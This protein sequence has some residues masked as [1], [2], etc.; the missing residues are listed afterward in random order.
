MKS[1]NGKRIW[2]MILVICLMLSLM[3]VFVSQVEVEAEAVSGIN[4]LTCSSFIS[5]STR[6]NYIDVMMRYY[7]NSSSTLQSQLNNGNSVVFMFEGGSD[8]YDDYAYA[9]GSGQTRLQAVCIVVQMDSSGNAYIAFYSEKCCSLPDDANYVT[10]GYETSGST[11][12][13][14]GIYKMTT[15]DHNG[16]YAAHTTTCSTGW[17]TPYD[18]T[19]GYSAACNGI[20]IHTRGVNYSLSYGGNSMGC[21]LIGYGANSS[22]EYNT[23]MKTVVGITFNAYDGTQRCYSYGSHPGYYTNT[24]YYVIDRQLGI[25]SPD[26]TE[27]GSG[28]MMELYTKG[29]ITGITAY[30]TS[31]RANADFDY[32]SECTYYPAHC[33]I[34]VTQDDT[35]VNSQPCSVGTV[36]ECATLETVSTG[37]TYTATGLYQNSYGNY[38][39][40]VTTSSGETGY[41]YG[42]EAEYV[43]QI[44]SDIG[45]T[46][47]DT[48]NGHVSGNIFYVTGK[49]ASKYNRIDTAAVWVHDGFGTSGTKVTGY[50][51][52]V[53][54][55][56]YTLDDSTID[57][58]T[59]FNSVPTGNHT[60]AISCTYTNYYAD[61]ATTLKSNTGTIS[62]VE[63]Y[64]V[65]VSSSVDQ[66]SCSH[67][68]TTTVVEEGT[69]TAPG[70][71]V[72]AC[73]TCGLV[74]ETS[75]GADGHSYGSWTTVG[76]TCT[77][78][79][80][81]KRTCSACGDVETVTI[82]ATGHS[83][84]MTK[85]EATCSAYAKYTMTCGSCG[86]SYSMTADQMASSWIEEIPAGM[87][88]S[89][90]NSQT[91][92]RYS[93]YQT[94][95]SSSATAPTGYT[96]KS[97]AWVQSG[98]G[99]IKYVSEW[100]SG[101]S[102]S[103][104]LY[105]QYN[106][107]SSKVTASESSTA[108]TVVNS[109]AVVGYLY[110]HWCYTD[111]YYSVASSSGSYTTFHAYYDTTDP[112]SYT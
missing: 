102:T 20:N 93:D 89:L 66:S 111:S 81:Q 4:S 19:T 103:S 25:L 22:N 107:K 91:Q 74:N 26:G 29:D 5:N 39:Y 10:P 55:F 59:A 92:Y 49:I 53:G 70:V 21:Q 36:D 79:G 40:R 51:D 72:Q 64:F 80:Y 86:D 18:G 46:D 77:A 60:Y 84:N 85:T 96:L 76:A 68:Y 82:S 62:L 30:S 44:T 34:K 11:T 47:Y 73:S 45:I 88:A 35:V 13:L 106:K 38:W 1:Q 71:S 42:G 104:S 112:D 65:V 95:T 8:Y 75:T 24:G 3:P 17:Y 97:S 87:D 12:I 32:V 50:S 105:T 109:D 2:S 63:E 69:C 100:P 54:S 28:S 37:K 15:V 52:D 99:S 108:K 78:D 27:Y 110:Y 58:N 57:Y 94:Q 90:F 98:T 16:N 101:F 48:P 56:S 43:E 67:S 41:I 6:Q 61:G 9:D 23:F 31:A 83:Y 7:I 33:K 14:D